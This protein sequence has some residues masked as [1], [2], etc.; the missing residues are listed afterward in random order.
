MQI[1]KKPLLFRVFKVMGISLV[2]LAGAGFLEWKYALSDD[3]ISFFTPGTREER[4]I[5]SLIKAVSDRALVPDN[6][7]P[8]L[9]TVTNK[10]ILKDEPFFA[11]A[12]NDDKVLIYSDAKIAFLYRP[13]V[14]K[15]IAIAPLTLDVQATPVIPTLEAEKEASTSTDGA[16]T[17]TLY[18]GTTIPGLT[19][20]AEQ[21]FT[22][23]GAS[24]DIADKTNATQKTYEKS[25]LIVL[26][27]S[28]TAELEAFAKQFGYTIAS[29]PAE[30]K[31]PASD[32]LIILGTDAQ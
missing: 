30:E 31:A 10:E 19:S 21:K 2:I 15:L 11:Q 14:Q 25:I 9:A 22:A 5:Q 20:R 8:T 24:V 18:N 28:K 32:G 6:E 13:K 12:E 23:A 7:V 1:F 16:L 29:L 26:N 27:T 3:L 4:E 17:L